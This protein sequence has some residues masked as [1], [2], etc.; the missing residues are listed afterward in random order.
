MDNPDV[1]ES[2]IAIKDALQ[3]LA[4]CVYEDKWGDMYFRIKEFR[5]SDD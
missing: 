5:S 4:E 3:K 1:I 2:I